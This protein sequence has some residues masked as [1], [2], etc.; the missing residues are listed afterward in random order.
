MIYQNGVVDIYSALGVEKTTGFSFISAD[1]TDEC[2]TKAIVGETGVAALTYAESTDAVRMYVVPDL[3]SPVPQEVKEL[4][5][6]EGIRPK[7]LEIIE[8]V[9]TESGMPEFLVAT[10]DCSIVVV[11]SDRGVWFGEDQ[12]LQDKLSYAVTMMAVEP[13]GRY[14][15]C[16]DEGAELTV[17]GTNFEKKLLS[18]DTKAEGGPKQMVWCSEDAVVM[19]WPEKGVL[20]VGPFGD[21]LKYQYT[22]P[23]ILAQEV[24]WRRVCVRWCSAVSD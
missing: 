13:R 3:E 2:V 24:W 9:Y 19:M 4:G 15:A 1:V 7:C 16:F 14:L 8:G 5:L 22:E 11:A 6:A 21:W 23:I 20:M 12:L 10:N 17:M 18:F